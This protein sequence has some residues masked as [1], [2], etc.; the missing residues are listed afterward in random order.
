MYG[1]KETSRIKVAQ[2][3]NLWNLLGI[4][5]TDR[6]LNAQIRVLYNVKSGWM[7]R[8]DESVLRILGILKEWK[9]LI[10]IKGVNKGE[11]MSRRP[12][13]RQ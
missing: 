2:M 7:K 9:I 8:S 1:E 10:L 11:C 5:K 6:R 13:S 12:V 3:N 4:K